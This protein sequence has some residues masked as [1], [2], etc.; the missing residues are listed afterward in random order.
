MSPIEPMRRPFHSVGIACAASSIT[1][2]PRPR[3]IVMIASRSAA[4]PPKC[5]GSSALVRGV[6]LLSIWLASM[7]RVSGSQS[8]STG[9]PPRCSITAAVAVKVIGVVIT[10]S[11][12]PTPTASSARCSAAVHELTA[13][14]CLA[15]AQAA[16]SCSNSRT[17]CPVVSHPE[18]RQVSTPSISSSPI[19]G[20][21]NGRNV[22][23]IFGGS[24]GPEVAPAAP[25][26]SVSRPISV[27]RLRSSTT[28]SRH[29]AR[30]PGSESRPGGW[31]PT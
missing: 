2:S 31:R 22:S 18:R 15:C 8:T 26:I 14:A 9:I 5:T 23:R 7:L 6:I 11:P 13:I 10:S 17:F 30:P 16:N 21:A 4:W 29:G 1:L 27:G 12:G 25:R 24:P 3:A 19:N 28:G 20:A